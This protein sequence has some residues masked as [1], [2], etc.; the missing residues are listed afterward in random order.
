MRM[1]KEELFEAI[2]EVEDSRVEYSAYK[3]RPGRAAWFRRPVVWV[4]AAACCLVVGSALTGLPKLGMGDAAGAD[5]AAASEPQE[6][7]YGYENEM[8]M[9]SVTTDG[10]A[11][12]EDSGGTGAGSGAKM[13]NQTAQKVIYT[14]ELEMESKEYDQTLA[15]LLDQVEALGGYQESSTQGGSQDYGSRWYNATFR[16]PSDQYQTF[17]SSAQGLGNVT[18][19]SEDSKDVTL[20]YVDLEARIASLET[21][22]QRL[23]EL[24]AQAETVEDLIYI[25]SQLSD[26]EYQLQSYGSQM[27]VLENQVSMSTVTLRLSEVATIT[28]VTNTFGSRVTDAFSRGWRN[29]VNGGE[30]LLLGLIRIWPTLVLIAVAAA[31]V[32]TVRKKI[33]NKNK[34]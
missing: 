3:P 28:P 30:N 11:T 23:D 4:A 6:S 20:Q 24:A 10:A 18:W 16:I 19:I 12:A 15:A 9:D 21:Q 1:N 17:L 34:K 14:A 33:I 32:I 8:T 26:L 25:Q 31:A 22:R 29:F 7:Y 2:G 13:L 5:T 27:R